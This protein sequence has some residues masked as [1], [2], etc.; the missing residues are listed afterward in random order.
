MK[1]KIVAVPAYVTH[2]LL[3]ILWAPVRGRN[4]ISFGT[5]SSVFWRKLVLPAA[6]RFL[7]NPIRVNGHDFYFPKHG[8]VSAWA[9]MR[10]RHEPEI[11]DAITNELSHGDV[12]FDVGAH[13]GYFS[14]LATDVVGPSGKVHAFEAHP[15]SVEAIRKT[16]N[17]GKF[18][19][20]LSINHAAVTDRDGEISLNIARFGSMAHSV[21]VD[22]AAGSIKVPATTLDSY[23][24]SVGSPNVRLIKVD[25]EGSEFAVVSGMSELVEGCPDVAVILEVNPKIL[26]TA[27]SN[28]WKLLAQISD[29]GLKTVTKIRSYGR[30]GDFETV[31]CRR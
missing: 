5:G 31:I 7:P 30:G 2:F 27:G 11:R 9:Y 8:K 23:W 22:W 4:V 28:E 16:I 12:F 10:G 15:E 3:I 20:V 19:D 26:A 1:R 29:I 13:I 25:A 6:T 14:V 24:R 18:N 21:P 17:R